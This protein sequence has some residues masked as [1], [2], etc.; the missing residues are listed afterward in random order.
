MS[1]PRP[2]MQ[3]LW[4]VVALYLSGCAT[5]STKTNQPTP[6][7]KPSVLHQLHM[8]QV[9]GI[10]QFSLKGR[11]GIVTKPKS[12]SARLAWQHMPSKDNIDVYSPIGGKVANIVKTPERVI[13]TDNGNKTTEAQD[14]E[15]LTEKTLGFQLPLSGLAHWA[16]GRPSDTGIVN[17]V[18]WDEYG[19]IN[20]MQQNGWDIEYKTYTENAGYFLPKKIM[21][22]NE[23]MTLKLIIEKW[24]NL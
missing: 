7:L 2:R 3:Y 10:A 15:T 18:T 17:A 22:K 9:A 13:L 20:Y 19:R 24:S 1:F 14:V 6:T 21:L 16:L 4:L 5:T 11:L 23:K 8:D 12:F